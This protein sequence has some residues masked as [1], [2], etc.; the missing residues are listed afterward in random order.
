MPV[1]VL[2]GLPSATRVLLDANIFIYAFG[3]QSLQCLELLERCQDGDVR[4]ITTIEIVNEVCH[5]LMLLEAFE[6]G[7]IA[8]ISA[9]A[10]RSKAAQ[11]R[12]LTRYWTLA[13][14]IFDLNVTI[15]GLDE[16]RARRAH[17]IRSAHGL[18][19]ND[20]LIAAAGQQQ[21]VQDL[22]TSDRDFE[23]VGWL[24]IYAPSDLP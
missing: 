10:L 11:I 19:T 16:A 2:G 21:G 9:P 8:R 18:L 7:I 14:Q 12:N 4:G 6:K 17:R 23:R 22:A 20:S 24:R 15:L 5:R 13:S 1:H 3:R